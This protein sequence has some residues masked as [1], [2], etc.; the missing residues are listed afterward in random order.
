MLLGDA[1]VEGTVR[2]LFGEPGQAGRPGHGGGDGDDVVPPVPDPDQLLGEDIGPAP[3]PG[4][5]GP[6]RRRVDHPG[7]VHLVGLVVLGRRV[8]V[9]L[10]GQGVHDDRPG[11]AAGVAQ[12]VLQRGD[13]VAVDR[14]DVLQPQGAEQLLRQ[15]NALD[16]LPEGP[17]QGHRLVELAGP[18]GPG[19]LVIG[20]LE[21]HRRKALRQ[22]ADRRRVGPAVVVDHDGH[23][24]VFGVT[25]VVECLPGHPAG[26]RTV[27]DNGDNPAV[28]LPGQFEG[29]RQAVSVRQ[30][31]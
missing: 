20:R 11:V 12:R 19:G 27:A 29:L 25:D 22:A 10:R 24:P 2:E 26:Q 13:V 9:A 17:Q 18:A 8:A 28:G 30:R 6:A 3:G 7:G 15:E 5:H 31:G 14:A 16:P 4:L 21:S 1:H 23:R